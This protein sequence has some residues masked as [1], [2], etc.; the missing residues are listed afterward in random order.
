MILQLVR[1]CLRRLQ[2]GD[3]R[4]ERLPRLRSGPTPTHGYA[5]YRLIRSPSNSQSS[6][7]PTNLLRCS[8]PAKPMASWMSLSCVSKPATRVGLTEQLQRSIS[9]SRLPPASISK[10]TVVI[11]HFVGWARRVMIS[12]GLLAR[13][14]LG[15]HDDIAG[16]LAAR[17]VDSQWDAAPHCP[18]SRHLS[19]PL[20]RSSRRYVG[21]VPQRH[22]SEYLW[23]VLLCLSVAA[24]GVAEAAFGLGLS[25]LRL[26]TSWRA[27]LAASLHGRHARIRSAFLPWSHPAPPRPRRADRRAPP[28]PILA[29][30]GLETLDEILSV[31]VQW[32]CVLLP[33]P[34]AAAA[35]KPCRHRRLGRHHCRLRRWSRPRRGPRKPSLRIASI[36]RPHRV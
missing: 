24:G 12:R 29:I 36:S 28:P 8:S 26:I 13:V 18:R 2:M 31:A 23:L 22:H 33:A 4:Q 1:D 16:R 20:R 14:E 25:P 15:T 35:N 27:C 9:F 21:F 5:W 11:A 34:G 3:H 32:V 30:T 17:R 6:A 10:H 7:P 19:F